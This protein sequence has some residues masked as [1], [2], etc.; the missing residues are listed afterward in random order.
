MLKISRTQAY[1]RFISMPQELQDLLLSE[2]SEAIVAHS[3]EL[4]HI[5]EEKL[6]LINIVAGD[7]IMGFL[8]FEDAAREISTSLNI[9][10][11]A[12]R[13]LWQEIEK[14][15]LAPWK[16]AIDKIYAPPGMDKPP[17]KITPDIKRLTPSP[18]ET[19]VKLDSLQAVGPKTLPPSSSKPSDATMPPVA[20]PPGPSKSLS[21]G[22]VAVQKPAP[23]LIHQESNLE[24]IQSLGG[25]LPKVEKN[26]QETKNAAPPMR[27][28]QLE[29]GTPNAASQDPSSLKTPEPNPKTTPTVPTQTSRVIHY[30]QFKTPTPEAPFAPVAPRP[31]EPLKN[32]PP[33]FGEIKPL[34]RPASFETSKSWPSSPPPT[35]SITPNA[36]PSMVLERE[37]LAPPT[38]PK[39]P[40]PPEVT[41]PSLPKP[42]P[43]LLEIKPPTPSNMYAPPSQPPPIPP[44]HGEV[45]DLN[46]LKRISGS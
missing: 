27:P 26:I 35:P 37:L 22:N 7:V 34:P 24:P 10:L 36:N 31:H 42:T 23:F 43:S 3:A 6:Y 5:P 16:P 20:L 9:A 1:N 2:K 30:T 19:V 41:P 15:L 44:K 28:A 13:D 46:N 21:E 8:H 12:A 29:L 40:T 33:T 4:K 11:E 14:K 45:I 17:A 39:P 25:I 38:P 32:P 18:F